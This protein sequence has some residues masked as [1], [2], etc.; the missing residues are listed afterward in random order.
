[1]K[2]QKY[3]PDGSVTIRGG[4]WQE[5]LRTIETE[6][7]PELDAAHHLLETAEASVAPSEAQALVE[8]RARRRT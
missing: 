8:V 3:G 7:Q 2:H 4:V 6:I 5:W 1:M